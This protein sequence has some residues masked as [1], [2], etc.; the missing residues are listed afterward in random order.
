[1]LE[2]FTPELLALKDEP[3][4]DFNRKLI[5]NVPEESMIGIR[6]PELRKLAKKL[7]KED[8][9]RCMDFMDSLPHTYFEENNLHA[10]F[11]EE[12]KDLEDTLKRTEQFLPY[13]DNWATCDTFSPKVFKKHPN[14]LLEYIRK[15]LKSD[16]TY[17]IRYGIGLLLSNYLDAEFQPEYL[18]WVCAV[19]S[20]EYYVKMMIAWYFSFA[21]VKQYDVTLPVIKE[22]RL[23]KWT[24]NK[25]IQKARESSRISRERKEYLNS[26]KVQ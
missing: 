17:T 9:E 8:R 7:W 22:Q 26:L 14:F 23:E 19:K 16:K 1:M 13:I 2:S 5:P 18:E 25:A 3:Y 24:H 6:T 11:I 15:W 21:L 4:K 10:F 20:E 12:I